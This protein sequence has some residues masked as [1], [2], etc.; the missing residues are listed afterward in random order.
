MSYNLDCYHKNLAEKLISSTSNLYYL[1][2]ELISFSL[3]RSYAL[4]MRKFYF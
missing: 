3:T 4:C 1:M 2:T